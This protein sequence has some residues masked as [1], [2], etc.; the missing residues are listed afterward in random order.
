MILERGDLWRKHINISMHGALFSQEF[1]IKYLPQTVMITRLERK[2][3]Y[4]ECKKGSIPAIRGT[5]F[6]L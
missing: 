4:C 3:W 1:V 6:Q 2:L 5:L